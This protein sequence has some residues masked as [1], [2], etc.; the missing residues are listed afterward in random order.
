MISE[1][2]CYPFSGDLHYHKLG[3]VL[4]DG[5]SHLAFRATTAVEERVDFIYLYLI[6]CR[7]LTYFPIVKFDWPTSFPTL[8]VEYY[9]LTRF[10]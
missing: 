1:L 8:K 6:G 3:V 10:A 5:C 2:H 4:P 7:F 9:Y